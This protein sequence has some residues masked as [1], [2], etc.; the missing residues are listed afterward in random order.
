MFITT[1]VALGLFFTY[2]LTFVYILDKALEE[3]QEHPSKLSKSRTHA[4]GFKN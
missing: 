4:S 1:F 3:T 2:Y